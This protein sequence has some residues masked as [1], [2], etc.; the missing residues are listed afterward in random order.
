MKQRK[1]ENIGAYSIL[2]KG[3]NVIVLK[4]AENTW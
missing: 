4:A 1:L 3:K 2:R